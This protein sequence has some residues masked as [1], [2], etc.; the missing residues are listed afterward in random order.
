MLK[1]TNYSA[2]T[3]PAHV[4]EHDISLFLVFR[5][6]RAL[7]LSTFRVHMA[8]LLIPCQAYGLYQELVGSLAGFIGHKMAKLRP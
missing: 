3:M 8:H 2:K 5:V 4:K 1:I 7:N 6:S